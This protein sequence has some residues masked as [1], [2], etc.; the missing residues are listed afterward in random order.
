[1]AG[2]ISAKRGY[3]KVGLS[4]GSVATIPDCR[5]IKTSETSEN[6]VYA[7]S[8]TSGH[9][10]RIAGQFDCS[11]SFEVYAQNGV[12]VWT[13]RR[14][15]SIKLEGYSD[16]GVG[17]KGTFLIDSVE[18]AIDIEGGGLVGITVQCSGDGTPGLA[19]V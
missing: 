7:S 12:L 16:T 5:N 3:L 9:K 11:V 8:S 18:D 19:S 4:T 15:D 14:G 13:Y 6:Q 10:R 2:P 17:I 1:M